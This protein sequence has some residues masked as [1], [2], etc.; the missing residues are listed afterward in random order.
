LQIDKDCCVLCRLEDMTVATRNLKT[1]GKQDREQNLQHVLDLHKQH[2][3]LLNEVKKLLSGKCCI[4]RQWTNTAKPSCRANQ[5]KQH[6]N[7]LNA[8]VER[9]EAGGEAQQLTTASPAV[10]SLPPVAATTTTS[11]TSTAAAAAAG[12]GNNACY[13]CNHSAGTGKLTMPTRG[14]AKLVGMAGCAE[15]NCTS[16]TSTNRDAEVYEEA[17]MTP[18][19]TPGQAASSLADS[20]QCLHSEQIRQPHQRIH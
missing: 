17:M 16:I 12:T 3:A 2:H 9:L 18:L 20:F 7:C 1:M 14:I 8:V 6:S 13:A 10:A 11:M 15:A 19:L 4:L 5:V